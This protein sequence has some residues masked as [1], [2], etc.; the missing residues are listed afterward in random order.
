MA[1]WILAV[2]SVMVVSFAFEARQQAGI[3]VYVRERNRVKRLI[4]PGRV[5]GEIVMLGY[6]EAKEWSEDEDEKKL[7]EDDRFY[8]EKRALKFDTSCTIGPIL[9]DEDDEDSGTVTVEI[10]LASS[11]EGGIN[12]NELFSGGDQQYKLRWQMILR[13]AGIPE[14]LEVE[15][16]DADGRSTKRH[17]L[18]NHLIACWNDWRDD[19]DVKMGDYGDNRKDGGEKE[20]YE[21][22]CE[23]NEEEV[24]KPRNG[25]IPDLKELAKIGPFRQHPGLLTGGV[26]N[27]E[28]KEDDQIVVSNITEVL[29]VFGGD[30]IN[31]N[32]ASKDVLMC[33]PGIRSTDDPEDAEDADLISQAIIDWRGGLDKDGNQVDLEEEETGTLIKSWSKLQEITSDE[34]GKEAQEYIGFTG[35]QGDGALYRITITAQS[36]GMTHVVKA[37]MTIRESKPVYLEWS[38][39]P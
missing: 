36:V 35:G 5:L 22:L 1:I 34:I 11:G 4:E 6:S 2:L 12:V 17:N 33:I 3:N 16:T 18:M 10:E 26:Y 13:N 30:K 23:E 28:D 27:P 29:T 8:R 21:D 37:K 7:D 24:Y 15:V 38:E 31:V 14:D 39:D 32:L 20:Y 9:M 25:P 19:D